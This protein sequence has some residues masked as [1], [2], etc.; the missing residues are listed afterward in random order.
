MNPMR[1]TKSI[2]WELMV[3]GGRVWRSAALAARWASL[4]LGLAVGFPLA[5]QEPGATAQ[6]NDA[7][8]AEVLA[9]ISEM[10]QSADAPQPEDM[11]APEDSTA[12]DGLPQVNGLPQANVPAPGGDR[13]GKVNRFD[14]SSRSQNGK[15]FQGPGR[16]QNDDRRSRG[17]R[18]LRSRSSQ[19]GGSGSADDYSRGGDRP[20]SNAAPG[21]NGALARLDYS[22]FM[23]I[24]DRNIFDPNRFPRRPGQGPRTPPRSFDSL[25]LVG[26]M[27]YEKGTFAFFDGTSSEY[28]KALKLTD[29]IAGYKVTN[30]A[31]NAVKLAS[32]TNE[33]EL[34][35]GAQLRREEDGPWLLASQFRSYA[36]TSLSASTNAAAA[37]SSGAA[38]GG[39]DSDIIKKL[40]E[41]HEKE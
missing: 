20:Q 28:Q 9:R 6:T 19:P 37:T 39:A 34:N 15:G 27:S 22:A 41:K 5:A 26:I 11:P 38:S 2:A 40:M 4:G 3:D 35:V 23:I 30:I 1:T 10:V 36:P 14:S 24:V 25:T 13:T 16:S 8:A 21:T 32:G 18:S 29:A 33:L 17:K 31:T 7:V 12:T